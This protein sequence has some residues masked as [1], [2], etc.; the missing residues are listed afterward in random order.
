MSEPSETIIV[1]LQPD[2]PA[3]VEAISRDLAARGLVEMRVMPTVGVI[4]GRLPGGGPET[5][6]DVPGVLAARRD[7]GLQP[8]PDDPS[9]PQ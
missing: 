1:T 8:P 7:R 6:L 4:V 9:E 5:V 3:G 2:H